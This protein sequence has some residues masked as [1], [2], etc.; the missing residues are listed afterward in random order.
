VSTNR[1]G[2]R[3]LTINFGDV[4]EAHF[5]YDVG[6]QL[7]GAN[8][9]CI[10]DGASLLAEQNLYGIRGEWKF[11]Q[12]DN[13]QRLLDY[14]EFSRLIE[15]EDYGSSLVP[16]DTSKFAPA[17]SELSL[18][19]ASTQADIDNYILKS[20]LS[21]ITPESLFEYKLDDNTNRLR[22]DLSSGTTIKTDIYVPDAQD[23]YVSINGQGIVYDWNGNLID[24]FKILCRR[25]GR[26][27]D[28]ADNPKAT[29]ST[30]KLHLPK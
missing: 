16:F 19:T 24:D 23:K 21:S 6:K 1:I 13:F 27:T 28:N 30:E 22:S 9:A 3:P 12:I 10:S 2:N 26:M 7:T 5:A 17:V 18:N 20:H 4:R 29:V 8:W 15:V 25:L 11:H 14:D